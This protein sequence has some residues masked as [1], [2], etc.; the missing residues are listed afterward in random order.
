MSSPLSLRQARRQKTFTEVVVAL[1]Q[2]R[3]DYV[4]GPSCHR[5]ATCNGLV[6]TS[7]RDLPCPWLPRVS[8][9]FLSPKHPN[10][11]GRHQ[12]F[13]EMMCVAQRG[14]QHVAHQCVLEVMITMTTMMT[15]MAIETPVSR[16]T[17]TLEIQ[18]PGAGGRVRLVAVS[19]IYDK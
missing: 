1:G 16:R 17:V 3:E 14:T 6:S 9:C 7:F 15:M 11:L 5:Q 8:S 19:V 10:S 18:P 2:H 4:S 13:R 12:D